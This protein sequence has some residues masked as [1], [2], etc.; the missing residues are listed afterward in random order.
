M[1]GKDILTREEVRGVYDKQAGIYDLAL[2][3]YYLTGMRIGRWRRIAVNAPAL[4][5]GD[6]V[7][8]DWA[9]PTSA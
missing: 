3:L 1:A 7:V 8:T 4:A 2:R 5:P 6:T 9:Y